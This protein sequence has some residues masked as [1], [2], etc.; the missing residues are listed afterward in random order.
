LALAIASPAL[1]QPADPNN[2]APP[3]TPDQTPATP[4]ADPTPPTPPVDAAPN[5][6]TPP[7][8]EQPAQYPAVESKKDEKKSEEKPAV[9]SKWDATLYGFA[10]LD[11]INDSTQGF[12][13]LAGGTAIARP[14]TYAGDHGQTQ[15][16]ARNSR[17]GFKVAAPEVNGMKASAQL[18]MDFFGNQPTG[19]SEASLFQNPTMRFRHLNAKL[20]TKYVDILAGQYWSLFGWQSTFHPN[21]V[22]IQGVPGQVYSRVPQVRVGKKIK[23]GDVD[24]EIQIA[25]NRPVER[26]SQTPDGVAALKVSLPKLK[27]WHNSGSTGSSLDDAAI[28]VSVIGRRFT[29][30]NF[31]ATPNHQESKNGYGVSVD[32]LIPIIP[33]TKETHKGALTL[34]GNFV[35]GA[36]LAD[37]YTSFNGG[38]SNAAL[39]NPGMTTPAPA[40]TAVLDGGLAL[41]SADGSLHPIQ[42]TSILGGAQYYITDQVWLSANYSHMNSDNAKLFGKATAV[43]DTSNWADG[44]VFVDVTPAIRVGAEFA[45]YN[46]TYVDGQDATD[47]RGQLS[48]FFIF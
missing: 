27:A 46:Q 47:Y 21:T 11:I 6:P 13:E 41:Y 19:I 35:Y 32:A 2:A 42:W 44:N 20:E 29:P 8:G 36:G 40:Y 10:E 22:A 4:P 37:Q 26:A 12:G 25:A 17:L 39:P 30:P 34:T 15:Y 23:G 24:V 5:P 33:A 28:G 16:T 38:V 18:E 7:Q 3:P 43:F 9:R 14:N 1:A 48:F 45:W 31:S